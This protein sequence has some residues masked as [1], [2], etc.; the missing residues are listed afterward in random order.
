MDLARVPANKR[1]AIGFGF[2]IVG[3]IITLSA[4][5]A[6]RQDRR[7]GHRRV[8]DRV[9]PD[10]GCIR[11]LRGRERHED[12]AVVAGQSCARNSPRPRRRSES[13]TGAAT[14]VVDHSPNRVINWIIQ[15]ADGGRDRE[16]SGDHA[17]APRARGRAARGDPDPD[18]LGAKGVRGQLARHA[19]PEQ[20]LHRRRGRPAGTD[21]A[22]APVAA[23]PDP[24][25]RGRRAAARA[26]RSRC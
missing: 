8:Q 7:R 19:A 26:P 12:R 16:P 25:V 2:T 9:H 3:P 13:S 18:P 20:L 10:P 23:R 21:H 14:D 24:R 22:A 1:R 11:R 15:T 4:Q 5:R 17:D 6:R